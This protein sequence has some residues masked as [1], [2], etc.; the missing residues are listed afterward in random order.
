VGRL[1]EY[2]QKGLGELAARAKRTFENAS[3]KLDEMRARHEQLK[4][5]LQDREGKL[6]RKER[7][8]AEIDA[9]IEYRTYAAREVELAKEL[10][11]IRLEI[12]TLPN[13]N[14]IEASIG[15]IEA[16]LRAKEMEEQKNLGSVETHTARLKD[17][18]A[19]LNDSRFRQI[20]EKCAE[21][22]TEH[23]L[24]TLAMGDL[25]RY[26]KALDRSM[27][28]FHQTMMEEINRSAKELWNKTYK[29]TDIDGIEIKSEH[30]G[31]TD[32]GARRH[33]YRVMMRKGDNLL[34]M[35][36][37]CS[38]GQRVLACLIIRLAL[39]ESF[40]INCGILALD[41]P[42][43]NL[44]TANAEAFASAL[45]DVIEHRK[46]QSN[47]QL[48]VITHDEKFVKSIGASGYCNHYYRVAKR[49]TTGEVH[50]TIEQVPI[51]Q[52]D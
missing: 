6:T 4:A 42:T 17:T 15:K 9:N 24:C 14:G 7:M 45:H 41:E 38:A 2:K 13:A 23:Y 40:C 30:E 48:I 19:Q 35:R 25:D 47:F 21:K 32:A 29:G 34:D 20:D 33:S 10:E 16:A 46:S 52:F 26:Y 8:V 43:T 50:S 44:D 51:A 5:D 37:R 22:N 27:I 18:R 3:Q 28:R 36:G 39:A 31:Y 1:R 11:A 12:E 49:L